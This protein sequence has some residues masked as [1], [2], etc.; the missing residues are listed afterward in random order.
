MTTTRVRIVLGTWRGRSACIAALL[1]VAAASVGIAQAAGPAGPQPI[2]PTAWIHG[3]EATLA[4]GVDSLDAASFGMLRRA[5]TPADAVSAAEATSLSHSGFVGAFGANLALAR[6]TTTSAG[7]AWLVPGDQSLCLIARSVT[8]GTAVL[9]GA[10]CTSDAGAAAGALEQ[11]SGSAKDP[12]VQLVSGVVPDG[13]SSVRVTAPDGV[14]ESAAV[15]DNVYSVIVPA[16]AAVSFTD[17][18]GTVAIP[19]TPPPARAQ[20]ITA[21]GG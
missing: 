4:Q 2:S 3:S 19:G 8:T 7:S 14:V 6:E 12:G 1:S 5:I 17:A 16:G 11:V 20:P 18:T 13:V 9:G 15:G 21:A 10:T